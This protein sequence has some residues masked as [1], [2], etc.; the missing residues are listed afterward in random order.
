MTRKTKTDTRDLASRT[1][2]LRMR[3]RRDEE[4][5]AIA[6]P[7]QVADLEADLER[8]RG[9]L[10]ELD[11]EIEAAKEEA[12][13][14]MGDSVEAYFSARDAL[15]KL[16]GYFYDPGFKHPAF[17][18]TALTQTPSPGPP[19]L[20]GTGEI[21]ADPQPTHDVRDALLRAADMAPP[22][23]RVVSETQRIH[24]ERTRN[25]RAGRGYLT[26]AQIADIKARGEAAWHG[27]GW[28]RVRREQMPS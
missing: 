13:G 6:Y 23:E 11:E 19:G 7:D 18:R 21:R 16:N 9:Q 12:R 2:A 25:D 14:T 4:K 27:A 28:S 3:I 26:D 1:Q 17:A 20:G 10:A 15:L 8:E 22:P 5:L 24:E